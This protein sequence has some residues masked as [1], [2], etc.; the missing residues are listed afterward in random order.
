MLLR[1]PRL[2]PEP[3]ERSL[4]VPPLGKGGGCAAGAVPEVKAEGH[5][6]ADLVRPP[7][8]VRKRRDAGGFG[9]EVGAGLERVDHDGVERPTRELAARIGVEGADVARMPS[10]LSR[11]PLLR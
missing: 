2:R 11:A 5:V 8:H 4:R 7:V 6:G 9:G 3:D 1:G 10:V